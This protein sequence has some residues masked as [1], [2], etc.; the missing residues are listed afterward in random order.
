MFAGEHVLST[1]GIARR[2]GD[3]DG[4]EG[5]CDERDRNQE[6]GRHFW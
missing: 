1:S 4:P 6:P 3:S 2:L 5:N